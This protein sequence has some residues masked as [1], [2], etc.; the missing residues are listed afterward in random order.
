MIPKKIYLRSEELEDNYMCER[1]VSCDEANAKCNVEYTDL[2]QVWHDM[3]EEPEKG[4]WIIVEDII[5]V[6]MH[7]YED[8]LAGW[9]SWE[10]FCLSI[11]VKKWAYVRD[12]LPKIEEL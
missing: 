7:Y 5:N 8:I 3:S 10:S 2:S 9:G 1:M 12:L 11:R 4:N 6:D